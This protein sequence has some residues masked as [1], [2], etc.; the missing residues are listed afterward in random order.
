MS[1]AEFRPYVVHRDLIYDSQAN[2]DSTSSS[3]ASVSQGNNTYNEGELGDED[4]DDD[5]EE[6][7]DDDD[8]DDD[9]DEDMD[10]GMEDLDDGDDDHDLSGSYVD[11]GDYGSNFIIDARELPSPS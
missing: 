2:L 11:T 5:D 10:R 8:D 6:E 7:D 9:D 3:E 4:E 1:V